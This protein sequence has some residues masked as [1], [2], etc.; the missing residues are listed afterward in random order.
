MND[1]SGLWRIPFQICICLVGAIIMTLFHSW[2]D[3]IGTFFIFVA[4]VECLIGITLF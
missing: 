3:N 2:H 4:E 1:K